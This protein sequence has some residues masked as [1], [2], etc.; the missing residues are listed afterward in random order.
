MDRDLQPACADAGVD[1]LSDDW[2]ELR[3]VIDRCCSRCTSRD[4]CRS[5]WEAAPTTHGVWGGRFAIDLARELPP[6]PR[7][8][9]PIPKPPKPP[10]TCNECGATIPGR[11]RA[12]ITYCDTECRSAARA[13]KKARGR[14]PAR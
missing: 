3:Q 4:A 9:P 14:T 12:R 7:W 2:A 11:S 1:P 6:R 13:R 8:Q 5:L 10:A